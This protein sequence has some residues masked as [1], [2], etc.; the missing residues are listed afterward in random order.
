MNIISKKGIV[1]LTVGLLLVI[2]AC[3]PVVYKKD[4][5]LFSQSVKNAT[6]AFERLRQESIERDR[7]ALEKNLIKVLADIDVSDTCSEIVTELQKQARCFDEW[8]RYRADRGEKPGWCDEPIGFYELPVTRVREC[9]LGLASSKGQIDPSMLKA[10][11]VLK[12]TAVMANKLSDYASALSEIANSKDVEGLRSA[13]GDAKTSITGV[14][15]HY[16]ELTEEEVPGAQAIGP[17]TE[18]IGAVAVTALEWKR[19]NAM[20][21]I[22][23]KA[24][25]VVT[26]AAKR[27]SINV[28]P[29]VLKVRIR[30][31][32]ER[33]QKAAEEFNPAFL[34]KENYQTK[35]KEIREAYAKYIQEFENDASG[36]FKLMAIA[37]TALKDALKDP[38]T[39]H[40]TMEVAIK[41]FSKKAKAVYDTLEKVSKD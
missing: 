15:S 14:A 40:E 39:Q 38:K 16:K 13:L 29:L 10:E 9:Q 24:D 33:L 21:A 25:P 7:Q 17:I 11:T 2:S 20:K 26:A 30:P 27:L 18:L 22:V 6:S 19:F 41:V 31:A 4:V 23:N 35:L 3:S 36:T 5:D 28:M 1:C 8:A 32:Q 12:Q 34:T 37:H